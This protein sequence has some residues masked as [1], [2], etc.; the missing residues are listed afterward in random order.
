MLALPQF[1]VLG[2]HAVVLVAY[3]V[4]RHCRTPVASLSCSISHSGPFHYKS[5]TS[6][7]L[8]GILL[9]GCLLYAGHHIPFMWYFAVREP[10]VFV[11][12]LFGSSVF[13]TQPDETVFFL[14]LL[15]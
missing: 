1:P 3:R 12:H 15:T 9:I 2:I 8:P 4:S 13:L 14:I 11:F 10:S 5:S 6:D 7:L